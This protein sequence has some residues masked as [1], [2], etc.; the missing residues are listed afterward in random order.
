MLLLYI[1]TEKWN[2]VASVF[3]PMKVVHPSNVFTGVLVLKSE[4]GTVFAMNQVF[5]ER[6]LL[7]VFVDSIGEAFF[8]VPLLLGA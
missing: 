7:H 6:A 5:E 1:C 2:I 8:G 4:F 3:W